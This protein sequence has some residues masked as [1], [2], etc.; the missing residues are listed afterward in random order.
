[1]ASASEAPAQI[2]AIVSPSLKAEFDRFAEKHGLKK[3]HVV[4]AALQHHMLAIRELPAD[5]II[6]PRIVLSASGAKRFEAALAE[7]PE[8]TEALRALMTRGDD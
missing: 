1:M 2:S 4:E 7:P 8:P 6:Q 5:I 3:A